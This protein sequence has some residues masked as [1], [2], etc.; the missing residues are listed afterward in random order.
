MD[1]VDWWPKVS[2]RTREWLVEHNGEP[3]PDHI[4]NDVLV[5]N[6]GHVDDSW[7]SGTSPY[8][9]SQLTDAAIDW[10]EAAANGEVGPGQA[11]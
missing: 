2:P 10:I 11:Q 9:E 6:Q 1:I 3:L 8:G 5:A 7:W 4:V